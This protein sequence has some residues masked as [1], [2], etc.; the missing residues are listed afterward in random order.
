VTASAARAWWMLNYFG[1][2]NVQIL[3][4]NSKQWNYLNLVLD[5]LKVDGNK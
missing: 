2:E 5:K 4:G 1:I 3:N